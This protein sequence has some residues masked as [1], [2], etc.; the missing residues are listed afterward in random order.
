MLNIK[1]KKKIIFAAG[2]LFK[3]GKKERI[4]MK[5]EHYDFDSYPEI[6]VIELSENHALSE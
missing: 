5:I 1:N 2:L 3:Y 4:V 6:I